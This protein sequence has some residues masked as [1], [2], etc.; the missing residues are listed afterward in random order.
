MSDNVLKLIPASPSYVPDASMVEKACGMIAQY[1]PDA[2]E[3]RCTSTPEI[4]FVDQGANWERILCPICGNEIDEEWWVRAT[5]AAHKE[6]FTDLSVKLPCC[7]AI[8]S[9]ND[10]R[11]E[12]PAG[13]SRFVIEVYNPGKDLNA[14]QLKSLEQILGCGLRVIWA[15]Y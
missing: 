2:R 10:L 9:P 15:H 6:G 13:F 8:S 11:Y 14:D 4:R 1:L 3:T 7:G 12:W 5:D